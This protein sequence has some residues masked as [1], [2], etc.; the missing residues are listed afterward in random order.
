MIGIFKANSP[1]NNFILFIYGFILKLPLFLL[2]GLPVVQQPDGFIYR[3]LLKGLQA[4]GQNFHF[5][6]SLIAYVLL[7]TQAISL[8]KI[9]TNQRLLYKPSYLAAMAYLLITSLF[10][11]WHQFSSPL[12]LNSLL[13]WVFGQLCKL[14][15]NQ[16]PKAI[17]FNIGAALGLATFFYFP[18]IAFVLLLAVGLLITR[19]FKPAE[20]IMAV[21][22]MLTPYYFM[23]SW[24]YLSN[25]LADY[26]L[27]DFGLTIPQ[28]KSSTWAYVAIALLLILVVAGM[29]FIQVNF[30]KQLVQSR[31]SWGLTFLYLLVA[32]LVPFINETD[33]FQYWIVAAA[34]IAVIGA[35]A[36]LYPER[37]WFAAGMH[38]A[39]VAIS[40]VVGYFIK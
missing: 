36:F 4:V 13:I 6:Y 34:P 19:P 37:N 22:G 15:S 26:K 17:L 40:I 9:V 3:L 28:L 8:N 32:L 12:I 24:L 18:V 33:N 16:H 1:T 27:P 25:K 30:R 14:H 35:A 31:K 38:W 29:Y 20:W 21:M 39:M 5:I 10:S 7:F 2:S 23:F 11:E